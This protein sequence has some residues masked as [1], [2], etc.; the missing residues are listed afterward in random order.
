MGAANWGGIL[1]SGVIVILPIIVIFS[2]I[3]KL[4]IEGLTAGGI[5]G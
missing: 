2:F 4:L 1:A 3:Q 5:K